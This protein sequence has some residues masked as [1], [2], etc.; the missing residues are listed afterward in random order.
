MKKIMILFG[1]LLFLFGSISMVYADAGPKPVLKITID[2][3]PDEVYYLDLLV[4]A[5]YIGDIQREIDQDHP[6]IIEG[7]RSLESQG[8]YP[9]LVSGTQVPLF[10][11]LQGDLVNGSMVHTFGYRIPDEF[12]IILVTTS[13]KVVVSDL[14]QTESFYMSI[15]FDALSGKI[16]LP[17]LLISYSIQFF[18]TL[19][20]TLLVEGIILFLFGLA[21]K[22]NFK[23]F[24]VM[25][26]I[27]QIFL[28][29]TLGVALI[30][31]GLISAIFVLILVEGFIWIY[32]VIVCWKFFDKQKKTG[33]KILY[34]LA[35]NSAS[36]MLG[37]FLIFVQMTWL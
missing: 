33:R 37:L 27:T 17:N 7:L 1:F 31:Q 26:L 15:H 20:P 22:H 29:A 30:T 18:T 11:K 8:W 25:N 19:I 6:E 32:E 9:A 34:A 16:I 28:T 5:S 35:A 14:I 13:G 12:R 24:L 2:H 23:V 10:G 36:F 4:R 21:S 3:Q